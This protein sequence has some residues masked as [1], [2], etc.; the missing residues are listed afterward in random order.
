[1]T[2]NENQSA[3]DPEISAINTVVMAIRDLDASTQHNVI[4]YVTRRFKLHT[5]S[6]KE[7]P[8]SLAPAS[9]PTVLPAN[10]HQEQPP[11]VPDDDDALAGVSPIAK[12]W[13]S[14]NGLTFEGLSNHFSLG[15]EEIDL[16]AKKVPGKNKKDRMRSVILLKS[17][18]AYLGGGVAR[19]S[20]EQ[21]KEAC[22][23]YN[24]FDTTNFAKYLKDLSGDVGGTKEAG[25]TLTARGLTNAT[26][27]VKEVLT[28][29]AT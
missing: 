28:S 9:A 15:I 4:D 17:I 12:K 25:Y 7:T 13:I 6:I 1:M 11:V 23:H 10:N 8:D 18:A 16:V 26:Q 14:R 20:H 3:L 2:E 24:A 5:P 22:L 21:V 27:M 19:V 29:P